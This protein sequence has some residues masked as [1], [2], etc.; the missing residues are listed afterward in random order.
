MRRILGR[1]DQGDDVALVQDTLND[2]MPFARPAARVPN[3]GTVWEQEAAQRSAI[4]AAARCPLHGPF[5]IPS[6]GTVQ[7]WG[8]LNYDWAYGALAAARKLDGRLPPPRLTG[9]VEPHYYARIKV[10]GDFGPATEGVVKRFQRLSGLPADGLVGPATWDALIPTSVFSLL[11]PRQEN[12]P[13]KRWVWRKPDDKYGCYDDI[14]VKPGSAPPPGYQMEQAE[15]D[16]SKAKV[17]V[18]V[19]AGVQ[20]GDARYFVLGQVIFVRPKGPGDNLGFLP[21]HTEYAIGAQLNVGDSVQVFVSLTRADLYKATGKYVEFSVDAMVQP[22]VQLR[23]TSTGHGGAG[24]QAGPT[25][26]LN[27]TPL[28]EKL[29]GRKSGVEVSLFG[30]VAVQGG[31][32]VDPDGTGSWGVTLPLTAGIKGNW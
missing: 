20:S 26:N 19:Q 31:Y 6:W 29:L 7:E 25:A 12:R 15:D 2:V 11:V 27:L 1:G 8:D 17:K 4:A 24:V 21:G 3:V 16:D 14:P 9:D 32:G 10:D 18:E 23:T 22:Y 5:E 30:Q 28:L 13:G